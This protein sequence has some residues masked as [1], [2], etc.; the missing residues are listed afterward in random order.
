MARIDVPF[1]VEKQHITQ[2]TRE[3]LVS[4]GQN[5]FYATFTICDKWDDVYNIKAVF[6]R[7]DVEKLID[8]TEGDNGLECQIPW[9]VMADKGSFQVG[10]FGG[11]RL[12]TDYAYVIV[13][14]GCVVDGE[15]PLPPTPDWFDKIEKQL[16]DIGDGGNIVVDQYL[17]TESENAVANKVVTERLNIL[18]EDCQGANI[19]IGIISTEVIGIQQQINQHA[20]FKGYVSTNAEIQSIEATPNDF[21][22][23]AES[24]TVWVYSNGVWVDTEERVPDQMTPASDTTPLVNGE[25]SVGTENAYA[26]GDHRHPS[27]PS[28][29]SALELNKVKSDVGTLKIHRS[30][31]AD[32]EDLNLT[33]ENNTINSYGIISNSVKVVMGENILVGFSSAL[34]FS[35]PSELPSDYSDFPDD[36]YFKGDSTTDGKFVPEADMRYTLVFDYCGVHL[37]CYVSGVSV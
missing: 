21:A 27:D 36:L 17:D 19:Q 32:V 34:Y 13:K 2:P 37:D 24:G 5:Y 12:L 29:A 9:E 33:I 23:S 15:T 14:Q 25:A 35:T 28:K 22:Y 26:R 30:N 20:H 7:D 31:Y 6:V 8:I 16:E 3:A 11:D 4:G 18:S 1:V 10:I